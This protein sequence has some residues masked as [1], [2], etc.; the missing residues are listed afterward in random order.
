MDEEHRRV[1]GRNMIDR[2]CRDIVGGN[3]LRTAPQELR[4]RRAR[5]VFLLVQGRQVRRSRNRDD[6]IDG[7]RNPVAAT[8]A[9]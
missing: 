6:G 2:R 4:G 8:L 1:A 7:R 9:E 3:P 5:V